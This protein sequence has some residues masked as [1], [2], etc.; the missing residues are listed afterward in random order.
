[1]ALKGK[2]PIVQVMFWLL[3]LGAFGLA[4]S[5]YIGDHVFSAADVLVFC[6]MALWSTTLYLD[7]MPMWLRI[8]SLLVGAGALLITS[9]QLIDNLWLSSNPFEHELGKAMILPFALVV[10]LNLAL[11]NR[12]LGFNMKGFL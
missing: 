10:A 1:V 12:L 8:L 3:L 11:W 7:R 2:R 9:W 5:L 6:A 4:R